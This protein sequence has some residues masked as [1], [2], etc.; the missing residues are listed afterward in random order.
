[1]GGTG[2]LCA[3]LWALTAALVLGVCPTGG[4][5]STADADGSRPNIV[6]ILADDLGF[7]D[8]GCYGSEIHTPNLDRLAAGGVRLTQCYNCAKC[9]PSRVTLM[10]GQRNTPT[11]GFM[12]ERSTLFLPQS[13]RDVGYATLMAGKW[14]VSRHPLD[15]GFD[16]FF[17]L[18]QGGANHFTGSDRL[19]LDREPHQPGAGFYSSDAFATFA[20]DFVKDAERSGKPFFL[21]LAFTAPHDPLHAKA[22]DMARCRGRYAAGWEAVQAARFE[23]L[24]STG[25]VPE[26]AAL[27]PWPRN[28]PRWDSLTEAQKRTEELRMEAYAAMVECLDHNVG[29]LIA[30]L[31]ASGE[32]DDTLVIFMS[33]NGANPFDRTSKATVAQGLE[34]TDGASRWSQGTGWAHVSNT[35]FRNYKRHQHEGGICSPAILHWPKGLGYAAGSISPLPVHLLDFLPTLVTL[36][37]EAVP[38]AAEGADLSRHWCEG[39]HERSDF[40][41]VQS[42]LNHRVAREGHWKLVSADGGPWELFDLAADRTETRNVITSQPDRAAALEGKWQAS[43]G[44]SAGKAPPPRESD[45]SVRLGDTGTGII[46]TPVEAGRPREADTGRTRRQQRQSNGQPPPSLPQRPNVLLITGDDLGVIAGCY[47]DPVVRTPNLD[48]LA[49]RGMLFERAYVAQASCS[50]SR[51]AIFTGRYPHDNGQYGLLNAGAGFQLREPLLRQTIPALLKPAGYRTAIMGKLHVGPEDAFPF[52]ERLKVGDTRDVRAAAEA[53]GSFIRGQPGPFFLMANFTDPHAL[54]RHADAGRHFDDQVKGIPEAPCAAGEAPA[55]PF[56]RIDAP[57]ELARVSQYYN[58]VMRFDAG[59][60]LV[61]AELE[62]S[63]HADDTLVILIGD[64]GPPFYRGKTTC[65]EGGV[66]VPLL[67]SWP[68]VFA[69][70]MRSQALVSAVDILPTILDAARLD[71]PPGL[72]GQSLR[73]A[74]DPAQGRR[75]L[76]TEFHYHGSRPF[77]PRRTIRDDRFKLI[78]NLRAGD[79][80]PPEQIDGDAALAI[81]RTPAFAGSAIAAA[82]ERAADPPEFELYDLESDPWEFINLADSAEHAATRTALEQALLEWRTATS[83]PL[84]SPEG[85]ALMAA[86][87]G[88]GERATAT[89]RRGATKP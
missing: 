34:P 87:E 72:H 13:L 21:Y 49:A 78:H 59:V 64:H 26:S 41:L 48:A 68:G 86:Y 2:R 52:D 63:G 1:M 20:I 38:A 17:G 16:R 57:E 18:E 62:R 85:R 10:T 75:F 3:F 83:D 23:R 61:L 43:Q 55:L 69:P 35:P 58:A 79:V 46:Y 56:Q 11:I 22:E 37:G 74:L 50:P 30:H 44:A 7:S 8:L 67:V 33:D 19:L 54:G 73:T 70:G 65:Y 39:L 27:P 47:G 25:I 12:G 51:A 28:L 24:I 14:H 84:V 45:E 89:R 66:R 4:R 32:L 36:A 42:F 81:S 15:R 71:P 76:A 53:C 9:E 77:F 31:E 40:T 60:G 29:R 82:F 6:F 5:C 80:K 88:R